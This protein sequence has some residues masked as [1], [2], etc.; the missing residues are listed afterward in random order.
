[1]MRHARSFRSRRLRRANIQPAI[2]RDRVA[3][4]NLAVELLRKFQRERG[5]A[6]R[7]RP[8]DD[9]KRMRGLYHWRHHA[10]TN[11]RPKP[12]LARL[13]IRITTASRI[14]PR[15]R[16]RCSRRTRAFSLPRRSRL[17]PLLALRERRRTR[18]RCTTARA[19]HQPLLRLLIDVVMNAQLQVRS[20]ELRRQ[21]G[22]LPFARNRSPRRSVDRIIM[23]RAIEPHPS[24]S[25]I[26]QNHESNQRLALLREGRLGLFRD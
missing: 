6:T 9:D 11:S 26:R 20:V 1:M 5:L 24:N 17:T 25:A 14:S 7:R 23:R 16:L 10:G 4:H 3:A 15:S 13:T 21:R 2:H 22:K 8:H 18:R 19:S 12:A